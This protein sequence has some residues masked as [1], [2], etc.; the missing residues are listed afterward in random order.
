LYA[1]SV[2]DWPSSHA[3]R[4]NGPE[5]IASSF[6]NATGSFT[7]SQ[8]CCGRTYMNAMRDS[9]LAIGSSLVMTSVVGLV[10][11]IDVMPSVYEGR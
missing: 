7:P 6:S 3:S 4:E 5:P 1:A 8:M 9:K 11:S 10:A 2:N